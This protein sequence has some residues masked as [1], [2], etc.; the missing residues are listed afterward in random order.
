MSTNSRSD[1]SSLFSETTDG[2]RPIDH[3]VKITRRLFGVDDRGEASA[4][5]D[6]EVGFCEGCDD[7]FFYDPDHPPPDQCKGCQIDGDDDE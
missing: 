4:F 6:Y 1:L 3:A 7:H 2:K 5:D